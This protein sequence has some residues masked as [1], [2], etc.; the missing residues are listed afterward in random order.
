MAL[1]QPPWLELYTDRGACAPETNRRLR[2]F[3]QVPSKKNVKVRF[4]MFFVLEPGIPVT[5]CTKDY[6]QINS[7]KWVP[8]A[9]L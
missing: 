4:N 9:A 1:T 2:F 7:T 5:S 8:A 3:L 6:V